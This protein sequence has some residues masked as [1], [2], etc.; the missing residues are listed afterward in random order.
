VDTYG[1]YPDPVA[2]MDVHAIGWT[3]TPEIAR[4]VTQRLWDYATE[5]VAEEDADNE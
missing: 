4:Y 2:A 1:G 5:R 3:A